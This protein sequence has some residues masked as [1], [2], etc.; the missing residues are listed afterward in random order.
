MS[1]LIIR[2]VAALG[3]AM[4]ALGCTTT[5]YHCI[6]P[7]TGEWIEVEAGDSCEP[8]DGSV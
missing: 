5:V 2:T 6:D 8:S 1:I 3:L 4:T 7:E